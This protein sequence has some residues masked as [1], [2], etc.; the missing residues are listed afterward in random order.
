MENNKTYKL[1]NYIDNRPDINDDFYGWKNHKWFIN[2]S[3][4]DDE[5]NH[6]H[7]TQT[8]NNINLDLKKILESDIFPLGNKMYLSYLN[9]NYKNN[10]VLNELLEL[11]KITSFIKSYDDLITVAARLLFI[12]IETIFN[13]NIDSNIY[14]SCNYI[15][16]I[17]QP[18]I[19]LPDRS[20]YN[21]IKHKIIRDKYYE[22]IILIYK[23]IFPNMKNINNIVETII[24]IETNI[25][26]IQLDETDRR[27][28][29][30]IYHKINLLELN[31]KYE[32]LNING[33]F[34][35]FCLL[36]D[37]TVIKQNFINIIMEHSED[38]TTNYFKQLE[39]LI[40][41]YSLDDWKEFFRYK[42][43]IRYINLTNDKLYNL[44]FN[45]FKKILK[46]Q[47]KPQE[48]WKRSLIITSNLLIEPLSKIYA[49][50]YFTKEMDI[51]MKDMVKNIK[52]ATEYRIK[53]LDWMTDETKNRALLKLHKMKLKLGY[54]KS[55]VKE[56]NV[57]LTNSVIK[58]ILI[59]NIYNFTNELNKLNKNVNFNNWDNLSSFNVNAYF[60]PTKNEIIFPTAILQPP[61]FDLTKSDIYNY[62]NIGT[63]IG[64]EIIHAFDDQGSKYDENGSL[65][66]WWTDVDKNNFNIKVSKIIK[67]YNN[68]GING[69][70]TAGENIADFGAVVMPLYGLIFKYNR[71][72]TNNEIREFYMSYASQ[73]KYLIKPELVN[74]RL[75]TDPHAFAN[76]RVNIPLKNQKIFQKVFNIKSNSKMYNR[77]FLTIW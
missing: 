74:I 47:A 70:L 39:K 57:K 28:T 27:D 41:M 71:F 8:Q 77:D 38:E 44:H 2:N 68:E 63:I 33:I 5:V 37:N 59:L 46:G 72:L 66:N 17:S 20:Y 69:K 53:K 62:G 76:L 45:F 61:F 23:E 51:Y 6:T 9:T 26:I 18:Q 52:K 14:S 7:F 34:D 22:T 13:I 54:S 67:L 12:N 65:V 55:E 24:N 25:A 3:I 73:W 31:S 16:Y 50:K 4:P 1:Y 56:Y 11:T 15:L 48:I 19:T 58:N 75:L 30:K 36:T 29:E 21:D 35:I 43:I 60:N 64:H 32:K 10:N 40:Y 42:I 49:D